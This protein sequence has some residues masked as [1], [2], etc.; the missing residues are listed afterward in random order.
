MS[1]VNQTEK[2]GGYFL[3]AVPLLANVIPNFLSQECMLDV[4]PG[5][6][7]H[8]HPVNHPNCRLIFTPNSASI[9]K[10]QRRYVIERKAHLE[11]LISLGLA[12]DPRHPLQRWTVDPE[13]PTACTQCS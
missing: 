3:V 4:V 7:S 12:G 2:K 10:P 13:N 8:S 5:N 11:M 6:G 1:K 9:E